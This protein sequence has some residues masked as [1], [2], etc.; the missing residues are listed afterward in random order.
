MNFPRVAAAAIAA[1][2]A[3]LGVGY[4]VNAVLLADLY[5]Q[6]TGV[7]RPPGT[8]NLPLGFAFTL[9]GFFVFAYAYAKGYEGGAGL[10]EGLRYGV[11]VGLMLVCFAVVWQYIVFPL[12]PALLV[13]WIVD[14]IAEFAV[15]GMIVG[16]TYKPRR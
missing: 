11:I 7:F 16:T 5:A 14:Y 3:S 12:Q 1:W 9:A 13:A 15:Y 8:E 6:H 10:Q 4:L 2:G